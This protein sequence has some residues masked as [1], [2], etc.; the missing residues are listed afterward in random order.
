MALRRLDQVLADVLTSLGIVAGSA[1]GTGSAHPPRL[2]E[3]GEPA[4]FETDGE[5]EAGTPPPRADGEDGLPAEYMNRLSRAGLTQCASIHAISPAIGQAHKGCGAGNWKSA[6][7]EAPASCSGGGQNFGEKP[8]SGETLM[9]HL[10]N[11]NRANLKGPAPCT[12]HRS[13]HTVAPN[14]R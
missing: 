3:V 2:A 14:A 6:E 7:A 12:L 11:D 9:R 10:T 4:G 13:R 5:A 1:Q 8:I